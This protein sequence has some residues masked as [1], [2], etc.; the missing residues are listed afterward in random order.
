MPEGET[1]YYF[2]TVTLC[3]FALA[4]RLDLLI[5]RYGTRVQITPAVLGEVLDGV[6]VGYSAL[7]EIEKAVTTDAF[8]QAG[9]LR[10]R[11][12]EIFRDLLRTLSPGEA[13]CI[14]CAQNRGGIVVTDDRAARDCCREREVRFTGT[15]GVLKACCRDEIIEPSEADT[16]L[17]AMID[18][19]YFSPVRNISGLL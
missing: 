11:E 17:Q 19:G 16:I 14:A 9:M 3:N 6:A 4:N 13:S 10:E 1:S 12:R 8:A 7:Q 2:D 5:A 18:A 15:I